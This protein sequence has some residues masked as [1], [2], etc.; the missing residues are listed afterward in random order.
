[1]TSSV[2]IEDSVNSDIHS[3][4]DLCVVEEYID[5]LHVL[6]RPYNKKREEEKK[7]K[8]K[9]KKRKKKRKKKKK[10]K[11]KRKKR[12]KKRVEE[13]KEEEQEEEEEEGR[14]RRRRRRRRRGRRRGLK[15]RRRKGRDGNGAGIYSTFCVGR[16]SNDSNHMHSF[17]WGKLVWEGGLERNRGVPWLQRRGTPPQRPSQIL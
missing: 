2:T 13:E 4:T 10:K 12:K 3:W 5:I 6:P 1:M 7:K 9:R 15:R 11:K 16:A 14:R 17:I 8:K